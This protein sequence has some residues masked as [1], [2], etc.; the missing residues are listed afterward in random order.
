[1]YVA[2]A[3]HILCHTDLQSIQGTLIP[4]VGA[5][6]VPRVEEVMPLVVPEGLAAVVTHIEH[7]TGGVHQYITA[8]GLG[9]FSKLN[10]NQIM[11]YSFIFFPSNL[12]P[13]I[14]QPSYRV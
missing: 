8:G 2:T 14:S 10:I 12:L 13:C 11:Y 4:D 9:T 6:P 1:M 7:F 5:I 3:K